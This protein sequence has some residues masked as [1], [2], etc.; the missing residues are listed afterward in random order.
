MFE[1]GKKIQF[2]INN[3]VIDQ[4]SKTFVISEIGINHEGS[5]SE[6]IKMIE[7]SKK[8]GA[9]AVKLQTVS[10]TNSYLKNTKSYKEFKK[11]NFSDEKLFKIIKFAKKKKLIFFST[12]GSFEEVD[13][14]IKLGVSAIKISSGS[15]TNFPLISYAA[16]KSKS[17]IISTGMAYQSEIKNAVSACN[18]NKNLAI[19]KCTS[20]YPPE[21]DELNLRSIKLFKKNFKHI[22]GYSDHKKD[23]LSCIIA[24]CN[25]AKI[26]EKHFTLDSSKTGKDHHISLEPRIFKRMVDNIRRT[27]TMMGNS[28]ILPAAREIKNRN[29]YHRCLV[30]NK[31]ILK[32]EKFTSQ[33]ISLKRVSKKSNYGLEPKYYKKILSRKSLKKIPKN[34]PIKK[35]LVNW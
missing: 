32:G 26:I 23:Y 16:K 34:M 6:C 31:E 29:L 18:S 7:E 33:N 27:E 4:N 21:D 1:K 25:G 35:K 2:K 9:D 20:L 24:V 17:I 19:L 30:T 5:L 22:I 28:G 11:T 14:L 10:A 12:P 8:A 15:M 13:R 3:R